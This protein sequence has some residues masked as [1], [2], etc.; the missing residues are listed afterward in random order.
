MTFI[1][2]RSFPCLLTLYGDQDLQQAGFTGPPLGA[3]CTVTNT[4]FLGEL[5][6]IIVIKKYRTTLMYLKLKIKL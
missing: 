4:A 5:F 1:R 6:K 3:L 2:A